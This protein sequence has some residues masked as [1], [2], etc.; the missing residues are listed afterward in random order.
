MTQASIARGSHLVRFFED[1]NSAH[2]MI[3]EFFS[4]DARLDDFCI[5]IARADTHEGVRQVLAAHS[6]TRSL[7]DRIRFVA[8]DENQLARFLTGNVLNRERAEEFFLQVLSHV[9]PSG[10]NARVRLYG[11][12]GDVLCEQGQH[13]IA[14]QMEDFAG[15]LFAL[16]PRL[17]ILCGYRVRHFANDAGAAV[18]RAV[19]G[20]HTDVGSL[21]DLSVPADERGSNP[22]LPGVAA[23][24]DSSVRL[25]YL[26]DDD[27]SMRRSLGRLLTV[28]NYRVRIFDSAEAFLKEAAT[29]AGGCLVLDIQLGGMTGLE[30]IALLTEQGHRLPIIAMS[31]FQDEKTEN[32]ALRLG[33]R[34]FLHKPFEPKALMDTIERIMGEVP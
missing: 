9:P 25:V 33:A 20:K 24:A 5:M 15:L 10:E 14:L 28:S 22:A 12:M 8:A 7:A 19:C 32:E 29:V 1:E 3:A 16:E 2:R 23:V 13:A 27:P 31:G 34:A 21:L 18:L 17:S 6:M 30:L 4:E 26:V 11:E